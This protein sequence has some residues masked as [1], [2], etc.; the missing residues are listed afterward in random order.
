MIHKNLKE[1]YS[2]YLNWYNNLGINKE[3]FGENK[4]QNVKAFGEKLITDDELWMMFGEDATIVLTLSER[5]KIFKQQNP[6]KIDIEKHRYYD[7]FLIPTRKLI[8]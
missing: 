1:S 3:Y 7:D 8:K 2:E 6:T 5:Q 4:I